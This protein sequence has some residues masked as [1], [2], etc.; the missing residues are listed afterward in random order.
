[1]AATGA[2]HQAAGPGVG[3]N[4]IPLVVFARGPAD[5][6]QSARSKSEAL[7]AAGAADAGIN[8][9]E[10]A[11]EPINP[12]EAKEAILLDHETGAAE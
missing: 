6:I 4:H 2:P 11:G 5:A 7:D 8:V 1:M 3:I 12:P 10:S 9:P